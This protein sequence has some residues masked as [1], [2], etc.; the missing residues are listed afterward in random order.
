ML[1]DVVIGYNNDFIN[2][3]YGGMVLFMVAFNEMHM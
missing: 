1:N 3:S 2:I